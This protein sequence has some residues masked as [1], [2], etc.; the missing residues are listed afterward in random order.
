M[1][2]DSEADA[3]SEVGVELRDG[4]RVC[5]CVSLLLTEKDGGEEEHG[6]GR[7]DVEIHSDNGGEEDAVAV[8]KCPRAMK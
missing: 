3:D 4:A 1:N 7:I 5:D 8:R 6:F 2:T